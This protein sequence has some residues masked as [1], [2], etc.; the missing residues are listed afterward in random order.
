[1]VENKKRQRIISVEMRERC[2]G[3]GRKVP[4]FNERC[5]CSEWLPRGYCTS[6]NS[7]KEI[8]KLLPL[9]YISKLNT[10]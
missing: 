7:N 1:V 4:T 2:V 5:V 3:M 10:A 8:R 6:R 9:L